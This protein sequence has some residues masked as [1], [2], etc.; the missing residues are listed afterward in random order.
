MT[1]SA[2]G[3]E[4]LRLCHHP[5]HVLGGYDRVLGFRCCYPPRFVINYFWTLFRGRGIAIRDW[6]GGDGLIVIR[7]TMKNMKYSTVREHL[8]ALGKLMLIVS[9]AGAYSSSMITW[10]SGMVETN[11]LRCC[12]NFT[13][14]VRWVGC[15]LPCWSAI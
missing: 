1:R 3:D 4:H 8:D 6:S 7:A 12:W 13:K 11:S 5:S 15:G 10:C 14:K 9:M 2:H